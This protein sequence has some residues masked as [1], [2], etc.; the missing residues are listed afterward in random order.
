MRASAGAAVL[1]IAAVNHVSGFV[2][3]SAHLSCTTCKHVN[4]ARLRTRVLLQSTAQPAGETAA[5]K[6]SELDV[7][8]QVEAERIMKQLEKDGSRANV[9]PDDVPKYMVSCCNRT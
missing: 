4:H 6:E 5:F 2:A 7:E 8:A 1:Y 9:I 3:P